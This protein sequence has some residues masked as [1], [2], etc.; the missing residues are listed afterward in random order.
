MFRRLLLNFRAKAP[1]AEASIRVRA[2]AVEGVQAED[3]ATCQIVAGQEQ[4]PRQ[5]LPPAATPRTGGLE[6]SL[7]DLGD[8][9][10][11]G[12]ELRYALRVTNNSNLPD[13]NVH[14]EIQIPQGVRFLGVT[15]LVDATPV[16][17]SLG[18]ENSRLF[19][20]I[21]MRPGTS[22]DYTLVVIPLVPQVMQLRSRVY[23]ENQPT[24]VGE[25]ETT[26]VKCGV[27]NRTGPDRPKPLRRKIC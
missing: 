13:R 17:T 16:V 18:P 20:T 24:P 23:S 10:L 7:D 6:I 21:H 4:P 3:I 27:L 8:P 15:S 26:T 2:S 19:E 1:V 11:V 25:D 22:L 9:T 12:N 14:I 5:V